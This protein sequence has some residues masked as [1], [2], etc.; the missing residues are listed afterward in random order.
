VDI[1]NISWAFQKPYSQLEEVIEKATSAAQG[2][3]PILVFCS[4]SDESFSSNVFPADIDSTISVAAAISKVTGTFG[5]H[6]SRPPD[7][8]LHGQDVQ[9]RRLEHTSRQD[10]E[11][12]GSSV[13]TAL[14]SGIAS[15]LLTLA[16]DSSMQD[17]GNRDH[18]KVIWTGIHGPRKP[19][20]TQSPGP[21]SIDEKTAGLLKLLK[22][23]E[24]M[25][26]VFRGYK[27]DHTNLI[28]FID[29]KLMFSDLDNLV[30]RMQ[31][32][33]GDLVQRSGS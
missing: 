28:P 21:P 33:A 29:P 6:V 25:L 1:I 22:R 19:G 4:K 27:M 11:V 8:V 32:V 2:R 26:Q 9:L 5:G 14:A 31:L 12:T 13:A 17:H 15:L 3:D 18:K 10:A 16:R 7:L 24:C 30:R 23:R 20:H